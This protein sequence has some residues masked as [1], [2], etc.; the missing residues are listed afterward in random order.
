MVKKGFKTHKRHRTDY[1]LN[2]PCNSGVDV[3]F[4]QKSLMGVTEGGKFLCTTIKSIHLLEEDREMDSSIITDLKQ[5]INKYRLSE[6][7]G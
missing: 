5:I 6:M 2:D 7:E 1:R 4:N 3:S